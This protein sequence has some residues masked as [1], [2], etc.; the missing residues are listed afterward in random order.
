[1]FYFI[2][3][4]F[5]SHTNS[6]S[7][8]SF[9][10]FYLPSWLVS[11]DIYYQYVFYSLN[12]NSTF[13]FTIWGSYFCFLLVLSIIGFK[14][15]DFLEVQRVHNDLC[16]AILFTNATALIFLLSVFFQ[17]TKQWV[18]FF[19]FYILFISHMY[20]VGSIFVTKYLIGFKNLE[21]LD[22]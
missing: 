9:N 5:N 14:K 21:K 15:V 19:F 1:M 12:N 20:N 10:F 16:V 8:F 2:K 6:T 4:R 3:K 17:Q 13:V 7:W 22:M 11:L 18:F